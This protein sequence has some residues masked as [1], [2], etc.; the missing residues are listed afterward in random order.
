[1][2]EINE[3]VVGDDFKEIA[4]HFKNA[5]VYA[6]GDFASL[7]M[8]ENPQGYAIVINRIH[9]Y[10]QAS[11]EIKANRET[12][13]GVGLTLGINFTDAC[14]LPVLIQIVSCYN[15]ELS[16]AIYS[17]KEA[18]TVKFLTIE[19]AANGILKYTKLV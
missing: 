2:N 12:G 15:G 7:L 18:A 5:Y 6:R 17:E 4:S 14:E 3:I 9:G 16:R 1:M 8:V 11:A 13:S 19:E 10:Y